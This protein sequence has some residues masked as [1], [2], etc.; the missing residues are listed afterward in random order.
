MKIDYKKDGIEIDGTF[1][2]LKDIISKCLD[3]KLKENNLVILKFSWLGRG[4][5]VSERR[6]LSL[7]NALAVKEILLDKEVYFGEIWGK[8]SE[9][10]GTMCENTFSI[11]KDTKKV[12][13]FLEE[14]PSGID[15][16]YSF[17]E[18]FIESG[19]EKLEYHSIEEDE[20]EEVTQELLDKLQ[21]LL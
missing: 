21:S 2:P 4:G 17:I 19:Q 3:I 15:Y 10:C 11:E 13:V 5:S 7:D 1:L 9:V 16:D 18:T 8:H 12:R 6:A 20:D 14:F